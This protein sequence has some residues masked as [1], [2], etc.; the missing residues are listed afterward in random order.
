MRM[1]MLFLSDSDD[2]EYLCSLQDCISV[3]IKRLVDRNSGDETDY[4]YYKLMSEI[5]SS[6]WIVINAKGGLSFLEGALL[7]LA[8][9]YKIPIYIYNISFLTTRSDMF[10]KNLSS[11]SFCDIRKLVSYI[12][13]VFHNGKLQMIHDRLNPEDII[14]KYDAFDAGYDVGYYETEKF[15]GCRPA[16]YVQ[17]VSE[18]YRNK[19][20]VKCIDLGCG[21]GKNAIYLSSNG[22]KVEGIDSSYYAIIQAKALSSNVDWNV[23]DVRKWNPA[24]SYDII[25]M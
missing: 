6:D 19:N 18:F 22:Y 12:K 25:I 5:L 23:G 11:K 7:M 10:Y 4:D 20:D 3:D 14:L 9:M 21:T 1:K 8:K 15:W 16:N 24:Y 2:Y 17:M 13:E